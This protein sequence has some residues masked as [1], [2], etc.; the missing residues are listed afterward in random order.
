[1][2]KSRSVRDGRRPERSIWNGLE[3]SF[4]RRRRS[5]RAVGCRLLDSNDLNPDDVLV[6]FGNG[7][8]GIV[9]V[10]TIVRFEVPMN[11]G[12]RM[13]I[14]DFVDML[15]RGVRRQH[16]ARGEEETPGR[17]PETDHEG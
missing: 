4:R 14:V 3:E 10:I 12:F 17:L 1:M 6:A 7:R 11:E 2:R 8:I 15:R 13:V 9:M 16:K 5:A